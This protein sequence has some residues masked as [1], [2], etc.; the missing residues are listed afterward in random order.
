MAGLAIEL[1]I[2]VLLVLTIFYCVNLNRRLK[3]FKSDEAALRVTIGELITAVEM[4]ERAIAAL[5]STASDCETGIN[6]RIENAQAFGTELDA[7]ITAGKYVLNRLGQISDAAKKSEKMP[8]AETPRERDTK[9][10]L[11]A[12]E[13]ASNRLAVYRRAKGVAA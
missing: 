13:E 4:A 11:K 9:S 5:R 12:A 2:L 10:V 6:R 7:K 1:M 3:M 8:V